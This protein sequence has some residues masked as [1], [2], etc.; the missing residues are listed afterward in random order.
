MG[1]A[2]S[3]Y[4]HAQRKRGQACS[5]VHTRQQGGWGLQAL[6][7]S[8]SPRLI[9]GGL[10]W[11]LCPQV[12]WQHPCLCR[13]QSEEPSSSSCCSWAL[14]VGTGCR[15]STSPAKV[16]MQQPLALTISSSMR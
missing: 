13:L 9:C 15:S 11:P 1:L 7:R 4:C 12:E 6:E 2:V 8:G 5:I 3:G 14:E 16:Q 10:R